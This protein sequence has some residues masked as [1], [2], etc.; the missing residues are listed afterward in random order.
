MTADGVSHEFDVIVWAT[1]FDVSRTGVGLNH[2][3]HGEDGVE[4]RAEWEK[5]EGAEAYLAVAIPK[6]RPTEGKLSAFL[7]LHSSL[8]SRITSL[9]LARMRSR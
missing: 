7:T 8:S 4:L 1:G 9:Y 6:V 2:G 3:V 5:K